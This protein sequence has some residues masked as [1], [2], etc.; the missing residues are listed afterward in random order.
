MPVRVLT[1]R[2]DEPWIRRLGTDTTQGDVL[3]V[4]LWNET[5]S[6]G[7]RRFLGDAFVRTAGPQDCA[8]VVQSFLRLSGRDDLALP[9]F[10]SAD[11]LPIPSQ[12]GVQLRELRFEASGSPLFFTNMAV[13]LSNESLE[14]I[15][16][17]RVSFY[18]K[19]P[20]ELTWRLA[21]HKE[22]AKIASFQS[23]VAEYVGSTKELLLLDI[24]QN[25]IPCHYKVEVSNEDGQIL[26]ESGSFVPS[27]K[28]VE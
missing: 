13:R 12:R 7:P 4:A 23:A 20:A 9:P 17:L 16:H 27:E 5:D 10:S 26:S 22:I 18:V 14:T 1:S 19:R 6:L 15:R 11:A 24:E 3:G 2:D 25:A 28:P 21:G 8:R